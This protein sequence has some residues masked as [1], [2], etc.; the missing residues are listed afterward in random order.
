MTPHLV[1]SAHSRGS[2]PQW[3]HMKFLS[4][5]AAPGASAAGGELPS[6][7]REHDTRAPIITRR[8]ALLITGGVAGLLGLGWLADGLA[9]GPLLRLSP[10]H[11]LPPARPYPGS[12]ALRAK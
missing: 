8:R 4:R 3:A 10:P 5:P 9:G 11:R 7:R 1:R 12:V 2:L 6:R